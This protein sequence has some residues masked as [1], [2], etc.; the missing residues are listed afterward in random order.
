MRQPFVYYQ[1][2]K[3]SGAGSNDIL[4]EAVENLCATRTAYSST[5][6]LACQLHSLVQTCQVSLEVVE[7][8]EISDAL[9]LRSV[10]CER[11]SQGNL[12]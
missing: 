2:L 8:K 1:L 5:I 3:Y 7:I 6:S 9:N 10:P 12:V 4:E 11:V